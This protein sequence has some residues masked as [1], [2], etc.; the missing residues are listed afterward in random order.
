[1]A[2]PKP[3][4]VKCHGCKKKFELEVWRTE[5]GPCAD[6]QIYCVMCIVDSKCG[7]PEDDASDAFHASDA[8]IHPGKA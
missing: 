5:D 3:V 8:W 7:C 2:E 6:G 1:M 4:K